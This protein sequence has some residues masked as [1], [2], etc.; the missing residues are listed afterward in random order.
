MLMSLNNV[1]MSYLGGYMG[2]DDI[3][4]DM[5]ESKPCVFVGARGAGKTNLARTICGLEKLSSG[6]MTWKGKDMTKISLQDRNFGMTFP[7]DSL[8]KNKTLKE[9]IAYP[10]VLRGLDKQEIDSRTVDIAKTLGIESC[11]DT[12]AKKAT[13]KI[14]Q[15]TILARLLVVDRQL[16]VLDD[17]LKE[18]DPTEKHELVAKILSKLE[19]ENYIWLTSDCQEGKLVSDDIYVLSHC[20]IV[21]KISASTS[22]VKH[23]A[24]YIAVHGEECEDESGILRYDGEH[25]AIEV[26]GKCYPCIPPIS[27]IYRDKNILAMRLNNQIDTTYYFDLASEY[28]IAKVKNG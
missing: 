21:D 16:Y 23:L 20:K 3:S 15:L 14:L 7:I 9:N 5:E 6:T 19:G 13:Q 28:N 8:Q 22:S 26:D 17:P 2:L 11:L 4:F 1:N 10:L 12:I 24:S 27:D 25:W 18:F